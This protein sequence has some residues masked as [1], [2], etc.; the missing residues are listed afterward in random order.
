M[1]L[2]EYILLVLIVVNFIFALRLYVN[3][4]AL[5]KEVDNNYTN[6][7]REQRYVRIDVDNLRNQLRRQ[8]KSFDSL[9]N[10]L[11]VDIVQ[12]PAKLEVIAKN[13]E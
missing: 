8:D 1:S 7:E 2:N 5:S 6:S 11:D 13:D 4:R 9:L 12:T 3:A 10:Y